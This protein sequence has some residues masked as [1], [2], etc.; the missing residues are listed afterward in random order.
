MGWQQIF[1]QKFMSSTVDYK[2]EVTSWLIANGM[3][4][5]L[6][7]LTVKEEQR[8]RVFD[9]MVMRKLF[10]LRGRKGPNYRENCVMRCLMVCTP[11]RI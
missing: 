8:L 4:S 10:S 9:T 2:I 1:V 6:I 5:T 3:I 11:R 7:L